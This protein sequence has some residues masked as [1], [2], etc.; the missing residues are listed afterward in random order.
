MDRGASIGRGRQRRFDQGQIPLDPA[1]WSISVRTD[2]RVKSGHDEREK[3]SQSI[4]ASLPSV[5]FFS[6]VVVLRSVREFTDERVSTQKARL[7]PER[8]LHTL[9]DHEGL[10]DDALSH[11]AAGADPQAELPAHIGLVVEF[12]AVAGEGGRA[13]TLQEAT[14][15]TKSLFL[16]AALVLAMMLSSLALTRAWAVECE[17]SGQG[18]PGPAGNEAKTSKMRFAVRLPSSSSRRE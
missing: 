5:S 13:C 2:S 16:F 1:I 18:G 14:M 7:S 6:P 10:P 11:F 9:P 8:L 12:D 3:C 4:G 17:N 15:W